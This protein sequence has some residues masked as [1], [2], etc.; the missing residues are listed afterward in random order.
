[1]NFFIF[2]FFHVEFIKYLN[3]KLDEG[4]RY[5]V[6]QR[7]FGEDGDYQ[8]EG[9]TRFKTI[10]DDKSVKGSA[11]KDDKDDTMTIAIVVPIVVV[12]VLGAGVFFCRRRNNSA[13]NEEDSDQEIGA[14]GTL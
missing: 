11:A 1:M 13:N 8:N 5:A 7:S 14:Y 10:D 3:G 9:F 12:V 6:F 2:F 4:K